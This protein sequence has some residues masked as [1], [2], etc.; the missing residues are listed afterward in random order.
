MQPYFLP[1][2]PYFQLIGAVDIWVNMDHTAFNKRGYMHRNALKNDLAIRVPL[3]GAS[4]NS[5]TTEIGINLADKN[6]SKLQKSLQLQYGKS[7]FFNAAQNL[8]DKAVQADHGN[9]AAFNFELIRGIHEYLGM[10]S[11]LVPSSTGLTQ[12]SREEGILEIVKSFSGTD[13]IN[14]IGGQSLYD[15]AHFAEHGVNLHF[16]ESTLPADDLKY[17]IFH[18]LCERSPQE[19][20]EMLNQ[21]R[22]I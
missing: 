4:Q 19:L 8:L 20:K 16:L 22:M 15:K 21:F 18:H 6:W 14:A 1:Y 7:P 2:I 9:L 3:V 12:A 17:S 5:R 13:Y 10:E 11:K